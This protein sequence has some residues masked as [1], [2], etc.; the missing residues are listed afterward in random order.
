MIRATFC[1]IIGL[2]LGMS[3]ALH[4]VERR[5]DGITQAA[6]ELVE[7]SFNYGCVSGGTILRDLIGL[8]GEGM[9]LFVSEC[10]ARGQGDIDKIKNYM[11]RP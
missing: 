5:I 4:L 9:D 11:K 3:L 6:S 7:I 1:F 2:V 8:E 10:K